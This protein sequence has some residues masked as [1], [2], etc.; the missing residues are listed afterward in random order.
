[1]FNCDNPTF[2]QNLDMVRDRWSRDIKVVGDRVQVHRLTRN[3]P[4]NLSSGRI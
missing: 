2:V 1:L 3:Q 4:D